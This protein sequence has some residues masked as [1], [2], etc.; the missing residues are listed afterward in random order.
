MSSGI[1]KKKAFLNVDKN[2]FYR[3]VAKIIRNSDEKELSDFI[4]FYKS[5]SET[6]NIDKISTRSFQWSF[7]IR[8][9]SI[10]F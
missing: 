3:Y 10:I 6:E 4:N 2:S 5:Q 1:I 8:S 7:L 9:V